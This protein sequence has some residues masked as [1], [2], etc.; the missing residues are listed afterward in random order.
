MPS[1]N[2]I[3]EDVIQISFD[4]NTSSLAE[5]LKGLSEEL[6]KIVN[7][8]AEDLT[9][10]GEELNKN[11][12]AAKEMGK[13]TKPATEGFKDTASEVNKTSQALNL[14]NTGIKQFDTGVAAVKSKLKEMAN[15]G[16]DKLTHPIQ[17]ITSALGSAQDAAGDF[18]T[19]LRDIGKQKL[20]PIANGFEQI[21]SAL[22]E[23]KTGLA[24]FG[25]ALKNIGK[26]SVSGA[27]SGLKKIAEGAK[28]GVDGLKEL[29]KQKF[30]DLTKSLDGVGK[31]L[32][33]IGSKAL[34][35]AGNLGKMSL[36][37]L[38]MGAAAG[39]AALTAGV[40]ASVKEYADYEQLVGGVETLF[41]DSA[42]T[43]QQYARNAYKTAGLSANDYMETVTGFSASM[44]QSLGGDTAK[45]AELSNQAMTDMSDNANKMGTDMASIQD[46]YQGF[47][48]QNYTMLDNLK[49][50]YGGT[51][52]E[53]AAPAYRR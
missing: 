32:K 7:E 4:I 31:K 2:V 33:E 21:K 40:T 18:V 1:G 5:G 23:G 37:G 3:R 30:T 12:E 14:A 41:G 10:I 43:V 49:L 38:G 46:A 15:T 11:S 17:T 45:A 26:I 16:L 8:A 20:S 42:G 50:G 24:G 28:K 51:Q 9:K 35:A 19:K 25:T 52:E 27:V 39:A 34:G 29:A 13:S 48:K 44:L 6:P 53:M 22:T 36:K 47:A